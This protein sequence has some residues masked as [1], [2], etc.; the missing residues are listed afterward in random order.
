VSNY[1]IWR[2]RYVE[3]K[4]VLT[5]PKQIE[6]AF[7]LERGISRAENWPVDVT[8]EMSQEFPKDIE[9][10]DNMHGAGFIVVSLRLRDFLT[11]YGVNGVEYLPVQ[12]LNHKKKLASKDYFILNPLSVVECI[13]IEAS[14]VQWSVVRKDFIDSCA[15]L[16]IRDA[17]VPGDVHVFRPTH[18][19]RRILVR[20]ELVKALTDAELESLHFTPAEKYQGV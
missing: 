4:C 5:A 1:F 11:E 3:G 9:L 13:D 14:E 8:C 12:I 10:T 2:S 16:V 19:P 15:R 18:L 6:K 7:Q 17:L 20:S